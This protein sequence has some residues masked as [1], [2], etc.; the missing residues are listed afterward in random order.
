MAGRPTKLTAEITEK[1]CRYLRHGGYLETAAQAAGIDRKTLYNW[2][3]RGEREAKGRYR[4]FVV[5]V[6]EAMAQAEM[7]DLLR[8]EK[9]AQDG[10]WQ[11]TAWRLER[12]H[13]DRWGRRQHLEHSGGL[14]MSIDDALAEARARAAELRAQDD[15]DAEA[16]DADRRIGEEN[17][18]QGGAP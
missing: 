17:D 15:D 16:D 8:I 4:D 6:E 7:G 13:G 5:Q 12:R 18:D 14:A 10:V 9:A 11:A 1:I 2:I 3:R